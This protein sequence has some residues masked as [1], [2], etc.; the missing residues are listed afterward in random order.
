M[1]FQRLP[2]PHKESNFVPRNT[3]EKH[4]VYTCVCISHV[5]TAW[6]DTILELCF[7]FFSNDNKDLIFIFITNLL[8]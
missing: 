3:K 1:T 2:D 8:K 5:Q 4:I 7:L 6:I